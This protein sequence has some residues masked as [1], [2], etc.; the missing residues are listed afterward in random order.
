MTNESQPQ[1]KNPAQM[2]S[3]PAVKLGKPLA[4]M[5]A[6]TNP[7]KTQE[8]VTSK[9]QVRFDIHSAVLD[10][11]V[12]DSPS[13]LTNLPYIITSAADKTK[14]LTPDPKKTNPKSKIS[15]VQ[16]T[17]TKPLFKTVTVDVPDDV[18]EVVIYLGNDAYASRRLHPLFKLKPNEQGVTIATIYETHK[19]ALVELRKLKDSEKKYP[20]AAQSQLTK[21]SDT[22]FVGYLTGDVWKE[23]SY[24]FGESDVKRLCDK[25]TLKR[26]YAEDRGRS[27]IAPQ[28]APSEVIAKANSTPGPVNSASTPN[29]SQASTSL[30]TL[31]TGEEES[32][33]I[34]DWMQVLQPIY[35]GEIQDLTGKNCTEYSCHIDLPLVN[36]RLKY[37][38]GAFNNA[39]GA[40]ETV[41]IADVL[42]R[43]HPLAYK[44]V[45]EAAWK[46]G[47][48]VLTISSTWRPMLGSI[49]HRMGVAIDVTLVDDLDDRNAKKKSIP[50]FKVHLDSGKTPTALYS[51][52]EAIIL[53][54]QDNLGGFKADPW[55][56]KANDDL[57]KHHLHVSATDAD[58][59]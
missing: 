52:F 49:L 33:E 21:L 39:I 22:K 29:P 51:S 12:T 7:K 54:D 11:V 32:L 55:H 27:E 17:G 15:F 35:S 2:Q 43:T 28:T 10:S 36:I 14:I 48:D 4:K 16:L 46:S 59:V 38:A 45:I 31:K 41:T 19:T 58:A 18:E 47:I 6:S 1:S 53:K 8:A 57:H 44:G 5:K 42:K 26:K 34:T 30:K 13:N 37:A 40:G 9:R 24:E 3:T 20:L 25:S 23:F 50:E 56:R